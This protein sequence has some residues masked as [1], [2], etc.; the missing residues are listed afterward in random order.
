MSTYRNSGLDLNVIK[1]LHNVLSH[2][3]EIQTATLYGS[4]AKGSFTPSSDIDLCLTAPDLTYSQFIK[5][6]TELDDLLLPYSIDLSLLHHIENKELL[7]HIERVG[8]PINAV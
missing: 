1:Q 6:S 5:V 8:I 3:P 7:E 2:Y 4:R